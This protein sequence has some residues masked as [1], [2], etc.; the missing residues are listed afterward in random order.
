MLLFGDEIIVPIFIER[1]LL[2]VCAAVLM[3]SVVGNGMKLDIHQ[4]I[5][6]GIAIVGVA[7]LLAATVYRKPKP[8]E[9]VGPAVVTTPAPPATGNA[10]T[11]GPNSPAVTGSG[12]EITYGTEPQ[13]KT[14]KRRENKR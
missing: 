3:T 5:G 11:V 2:V 6:L 9:S 10:A 4:R 8:P 13:K 12:N 14:N 7:Y 1:F